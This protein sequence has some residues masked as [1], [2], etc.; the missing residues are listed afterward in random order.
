MGQPMSG[1]RHSRT[2]VGMQIVPT[3]PVDELIDTIVVAESLGYGYAMVADEGLM[4]DVYATLGAAAKATR[5][6][7]RRSWR[8]SRL[9]RGGRRAWSVPLPAR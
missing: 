2:I 7:G 9:I 1:R 6:R 3:M 5:T 8:L 4:H